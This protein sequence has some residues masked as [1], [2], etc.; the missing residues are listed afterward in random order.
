VQYPGSQLA[1]S[2]R[3][4]AALVA[5]GMET[6]VYFCSLSGFDTHSNQFNNHQRLLGELSNS[7]AAFQQDLERQGLDQQVLTM[8]FSEFG[9]RPYENVALG[10]D[11]GTA[12][13][14]FLMGSA[15]KA[16]NGLIG[17]AP[18]LRIPD[19]GDLTYKIDFRQVYATV[20]KRW[21]DSDPS[22]V[23]GAKPFEEIPIL[24]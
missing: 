11:H 16:K 14:L 13:P 6:R 3:R 22:A 23:L 1:Q 20:L 12:A 19:K 21:L 8:T 24:A 15:L 18:D 4:V 10:T 5:S 2:L 9:R 17:E 7:L